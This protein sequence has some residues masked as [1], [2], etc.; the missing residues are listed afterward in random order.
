MPTCLNRRSLL[1]GLTATTMTAALTPVSAAPRARFFKRIGKPIGI[2]LYTLGEEPAKDLDAVF[3]RL[4]A[5]GYGDVQLSQLYGRT[6][7]QLKAAAGK[8]GLAITSM[9][10][11]AL[12]AGQPDTLLLTSSPQKIAD[13]FGELGI[14]QAVLPIFPLPANFR[15]DKGEDFRVAIARLAQDAD[16]WT[17]TAALLNE[18]AAALKPF[19][20]S[21]GYHNHNVEFAPLGGTTGWDI[22]VNETQ[23]GLVE[24]ELDVGWVASAGIDPAAMLQRLSGRVSHLHVKDLKASTKSNFALAMDPCEVGSGRQDWSGILAAADKAGVRH[25]YVEQEP[26]FAMPRLDAAAKSYA[27]LAKLRA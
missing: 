13:A 5:I 9:H 8:A 11:A 23:P 25:Y 1:A 16:M 15:P 19:G 17:R 12:A 18:R 22:L 20:I 14:H 27:Y 21:L 24:F 2:Q 7:A 3:A 26:P 4:A 10:L 6:P